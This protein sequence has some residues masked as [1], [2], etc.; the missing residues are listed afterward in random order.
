M[1]K[2]F[3]WGLIITIVGGL[4]VVYT[5]A[6]LAFA[7]PMEWAIKWFGI[8]GGSRFGYKLIGIII[9]IVGLLIMTGLLPSVLMA[10]VGRLFLPL[11]R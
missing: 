2:S 11:A 5:E 9:I 6:I 8:Y 10:T 7:G 4:I 3:I 1:L